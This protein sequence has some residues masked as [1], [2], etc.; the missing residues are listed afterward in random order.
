MVGDD[1]EVGAK[2][3]I[4]GMEPLQFAARNRSMANAG[5]AAMVDRRVSV[6]GR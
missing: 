2:L 3:K 5:E 6:S 1:K 4:I